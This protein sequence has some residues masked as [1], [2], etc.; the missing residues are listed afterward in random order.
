MYIREG[1]QFN[2]IG[3]LST[4]AEKTFESLTVELQYP[5]KKT[6]I[7]TIYRSPNPPHLCSVLDHT[8]RFIQLL[9][10]H[11]H[12]LYNLNKMTVVFLDSNINLHGIQNDPLATNYLNTIISSG[13]LQVITKSTRIQGN[14]HSLIDHILIKENLH[15]RCHGT[16]VS[17]LSDHFINFH[18]INSS[19][20][21][22]K[23]TLHTS[24]KITLD[25]M[26]RFKSLLLGTDWSRVSDSGTVDVAFD[27]FWKE[28]GQLYELCFPETVCKLNRNIHR[29]NDYMTLG[30]KIKKKCSTQNSAY[31][32]FN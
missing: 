7:S 16:I 32:P 5:N 24:R 3:N 6:I 17:D 21:K 25:N 27:E 29:L 10:S 12:D 9:S 1:L 28:F 20:E 26:N 14:S 31:I 18:Q 2:K 13:F 4:F 11:L 8:T 22:S 30:F 19:T 15:E 23:Q